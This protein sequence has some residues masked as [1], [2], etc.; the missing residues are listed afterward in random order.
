MANDRF[1]IRKRTSGQL[2]VA[3]MTY[4]ASPPQILIYGLGAIG[5]KLMYSLCQL[6]QLIITKIRSSFAGL[7]NADL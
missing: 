5:G 3:L 6:K 2:S 4:F 1:L 7:S